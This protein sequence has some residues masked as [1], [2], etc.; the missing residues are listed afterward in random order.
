M[1]VR[2]SASSKPGEMAK[3][4]EVEII[5]RAPWS[6]SHRYTV[7]IE[8]AESDGQPSIHIENAGAQISVPTAESADANSGATHITPVGFHRD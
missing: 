5:I 6:P 8:P 4:T 7:T 1:E 2:L 3:Q